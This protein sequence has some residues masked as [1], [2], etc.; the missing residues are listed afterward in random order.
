MNLIELW[1]FIRFLYLAFNNEIF[2]LLVCV[3]VGPPSFELNYK[4]ISF[5]IQLFVRVEF[6]KKTQHKGSNFGNQQLNVKKKKTIKSQTDNKL[7]EKINLE[8][9]I[10]VAF[11]RWLFYLFG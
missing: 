7:E 11:V 6:T 9:L 5:S 3:L 10:Q 2:C 4:F 1:F 8:H